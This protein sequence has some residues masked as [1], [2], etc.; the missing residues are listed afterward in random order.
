MSAPVQGSPRGIERPVGADA[1]QHANPRSWVLAAVI[2][3]FMA[4]GI[5]IIVQ[6]WWLFWLSAAIILLSGPACGLMPR[7]LTG[8]HRQL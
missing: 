2:V 5:A 4:A 1:C 8:N 3:A 6:M 7:T